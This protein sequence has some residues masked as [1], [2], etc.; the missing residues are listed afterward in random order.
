V[1][2]NRQVLLTTPQRKQGAQRH[3]KYDV[4]D[5]VGREAPAGTE[6]AGWVVKLVAPESWRQAG[7]Q[8]TIQCADGSLAVSQTGAGHYQLRVFLQKLRL[9]RG[10]TPRTRDPGAP[11]D[12]ATRLERAWPKLR[13]PVTVTFLEPA[14]LVR[15]LSELEVA[16]RTQ[17]LVDWMALGAAGITPDAKGIVQVDA[18]PLSEALVE[19]LQ[20]LELTYRI[21][22]P[23]LFEVTTRKAA[24]ARLELEFYPVGRLLTAGQSGEAL[25]ERI[26]GQVAGP[27]WSDAGGPGLLH[28]DKPS[29]H[30]M[31]LQSQPVQAKV[32]ILLNGL[33]AEQRGAASR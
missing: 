8:G 19:L 11:S 22:G 13:Q 23:D 3:E 9:A 30:L 5:L 1:V 10:L 16:S 21:I 18:R 32:Q 31:V 7:G 6:L 25:M 12:V 29:K 27:T 33:A 17:I 2:A 26:K 28:F 24:A 14:P 4:A 20:P 15:I